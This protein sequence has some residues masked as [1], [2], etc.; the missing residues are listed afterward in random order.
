MSGDEQAKMEGP[1]ELPSPPRRPTSSRRPRLRRRSSEAR[2]AAERELSSVR[3]ALE[4]DL[5]TRAGRSPRSNPRR[6]NARGI[7][8]SKELRPTGRLKP[9]A[10]TCWP[11]GRGGGG[12]CQVDAAH[13]TAIAAVEARRRR[14]RKRR[15]NARGSN[16]R[17]T[18]RKSRRCRRGLS[19]RKRLSWAFSASRALLD[20]TTPSV[21]RDWEDMKRRFDARESRADDVAQI[22]GPKQEVGVLAQTCANLKIEK[23]HLA[24]EL[25]NRDVTDAVSA[26][27][28]LRGTTPGPRTRRERQERVGQH[29]TPSPNV[30]AR[31]AATVSSAA[32]ISSRNRSS[33]RRYEPRPPRRGVCGPRRR[34]GGRR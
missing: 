1:P 33:R 2:T 7:S 3:S 22:K 19:S 30:R 14:R 27:P 26:T 11:P 31:R 25:E 28:G 21:K 29:A 13:A 9:P 12:G 8:A 34:A 16:G 4:A 5:E 10:P 20:E 17:S 23:T 18:R 32:T 15:R 24:L 6:R